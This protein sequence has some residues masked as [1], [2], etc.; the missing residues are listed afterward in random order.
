M[1][2]LF[3]SFTLFYLTDCF[4]T[5]KGHFLWMIKKSIFRH[6]KKQLI[7]D[8]SCWGHVILRKLENFTDFKFQYVYLG[9]KL[10]F[11]FKIRKIVK[12]IKMVIL[13]VWKMKRSSNLAKSIGIICFIIKIKSSLSTSVLIFSTISQILKTKFYVF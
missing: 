1:Q 5:Y 9:K 13:L 2:R 10:N 4:S 12:K 11:V 6:F 7:E 8:L 3:N